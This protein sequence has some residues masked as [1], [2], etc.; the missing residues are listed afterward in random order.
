MKDYIA[1]LK[2][3]NGTVPFENTPYEYQYL[4]EIIIFSIL[5]AYQALVFRCQDKKNG[6]KRLRVI[7]RRRLVA[8]LFER[9]D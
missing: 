3:R 9:C 1:P 6:F 5:E 8:A 4:I 2:T 7:G